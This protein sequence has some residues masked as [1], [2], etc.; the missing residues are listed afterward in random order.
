MGNFTV[1][2]A[3]LDITP[4]LGCHMCGYF[5]VMKRLYKT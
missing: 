5:E 1:G 2:T 3:K 4:G